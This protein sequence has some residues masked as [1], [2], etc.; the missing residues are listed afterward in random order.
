MSLSLFLLLVPA[1]PPPPPVAVP[2]TRALVSWTP[3]EVRCGGTIVEGGVVRRPLGSLGFQPPRSNDQVTYRF[4]IDASGR[5]V[6]LAR[7]EGGGPLFASDIGPALAASRFP[8]G[9][10]RED[11]R[12]TYSARAW[13]IE[14]APVEDLVS[15]TITPTSGRLPAEG[16]ARIQAEGLCARAPRPRVLLRAFPDFRRIAGTSGVKDWS[17]VGFDIDESGAPMKMRT[18]HTTGNA[19]LDAAA[20]EAV[21]D[22]RFTKGA[23]S[24]CLYPYWKA[25]DRLPAPPVPDEAALRPE[26][27]SC[28]AKPKWDS[29]PVLNF[30]E[31]WRRR[32]IEGWAIVSYDV[33]PWGAIGNVK[34][35]ASQPSDDFGRHAI[36]IMQSGRAVAS[37]QG[38]TG[39]VETVRFVIGIGERQPDDDGEVGIF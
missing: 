4:A 21:G 1:T 27:S 8:A 31:A 7:Q 30:P 38:T 39:C 5:P 15:Y 23:R 3:G 17:L 28:A 34:V 36:G 20:T 14:T 24:G 32:S 19:A 35:L 33:A 26:A 25:A 22:S 11:C 13:A 37:A 18:V 12:V 6:S 9:A 16:W 2:G 10:V 29:W